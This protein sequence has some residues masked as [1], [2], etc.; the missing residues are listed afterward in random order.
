MDIKTLKWYV[1]IESRNSHSFKKFNIFEHGGVVG[2][3]ERFM[4]KNP[5]KEELSEEL[6][7]I[8]GYYFWKKCEY[9]IL[10]CSWPPNDRNPLEK[11]VD[12]VDQ[13]ELNWDNFVDCVWQCYMKEDC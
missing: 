2:Q 4:K 12:I 3:L 5:S 10:I 8:V 9:E 1:V 11:K 7:N 13:L 6:R